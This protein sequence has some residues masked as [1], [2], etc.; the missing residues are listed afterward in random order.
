[1][2]PEVERAV[3]E[4]VRRL[5]VGTGDRRRETGATETGHQTEDG[6]PL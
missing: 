1:M 2:T 6:A 4:V 3:E 5:R